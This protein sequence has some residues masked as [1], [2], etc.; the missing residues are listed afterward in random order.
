[1]YLAG[2][3][4]L[5]NFYQDLYN[6]KYVKSVHTVKLIRIEFQAITKIHSLF[7]VSV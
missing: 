6:N 5:L 4:E 3:E 2:M 1:M 7:Y